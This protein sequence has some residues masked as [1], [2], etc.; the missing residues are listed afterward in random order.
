MANVLFNVTPAPRELLHLL[1]LGLSYPW[2][3]YVMILLVVLP[4]SWCDVNGDV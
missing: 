2:L 3:P 1:Q 4:V